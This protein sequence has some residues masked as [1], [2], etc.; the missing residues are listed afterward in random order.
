MD[1]LLL[2]KT[3]LNGTGI[4][5]IERLRASN[6]DAFA[7]LSVSCA[8]GLPVGAA[9]AT[10]P[11]AAT[12]PC[13]EHSDSPLAGRIGAILE[14]QRGLRVKGEGAWN[15][16]DRNARLWR[17]ADSILAFGAHVQ[18]D[19]DPSDWQPRSHDLTLRERQVVS[20]VGRGCSNKEI[21]REMR[22]SYSTVKNYV[23][24]ILEKL[25]LDGRTQIA[26]FAQRAGS[27]RMME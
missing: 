27:E 6:P 23:S 16:L 7:V 8:C 24:S 26:L 9:G 20:L 4:D 10:S 11:S 14:R 15:G 2:D 13:P 5:L 18:L 12:A 21:A 1:I 3:R 17:T 22:L 19:P 25:G